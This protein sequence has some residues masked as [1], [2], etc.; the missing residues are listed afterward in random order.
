MPVLPRT[1]RHTGPPTD[2]FDGERF[3]NAAETVHAS[4]GGL[5]KWML[6]RER[7]SWQSFIDAEPGPAPPPRV[8]VG[9]L[10]VTF[11]GH[12]T[13]LV[14]MD[15]L[16]LLTDPVWSNRASP[17]GWVG[18]RRHRP[19]GIRFEDLPPIDVVLLSHNHYDHLDVDTLRR[20]AET[21]SPRIVTGLGNAALCEAEG[22]GGAEDLDWW[23]STRASEQVRIVSV[24]ARHF[25][26][27]GLGDRD[28]TLWMGHV[29]EG[30]AGRV[31]FAGDSGY[32]DHFT[33]IRERLGAPR[34]ALL[35]IGAYEPRW[36]MQAVHMNPEE[37]VRAHV[38]LD[39]GTSVGIHFGTFRLT[40]EGQDEP[41]A[42][43]GRALT[44]ASA[45]ARGAP[46]FWVLDHGEG[47]DV[48]AHDAHATA[49][50]ARAAAE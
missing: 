41:V 16:N 1:T 39:A 32:G 13:V 15:G 36:F 46:R 27:R 5:A 45:E 50:D 25:S 38:D 2:H 42:A 48:P 43:L 14:Q 12:A 9:E 33:H 40:D 24:P 34:L 47:R 26:G 10:R 7:G 21:H 17:F 8:G 31:Y 49:T 30:P 23:Q 44:A 28:Q 4:A 37:A 18:P 29:V 19:P 11:V 35:P 6:T 20:L 3:R 22:I